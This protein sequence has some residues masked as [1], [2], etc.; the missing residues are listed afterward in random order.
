MSPDFQIWK[1]YLPSL[2]FRPSKFGKWPYGESPNLEGRI[3]KV[4]RPKFQIWKPGDIEGPSPEFV[5]IYFQKSSKNP[6]LYVTLQKNI[7]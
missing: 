5:K 7:V 3:S 6:T 4:G 2:E 1:L